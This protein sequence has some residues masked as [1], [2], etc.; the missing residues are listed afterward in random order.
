[1]MHTYSIITLS[2]AEKNLFYF[3]GV[4][5]HNHLRSHD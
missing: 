1:M 3:T 4:E 5:G 2:V